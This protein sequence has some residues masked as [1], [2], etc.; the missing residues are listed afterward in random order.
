MRRQRVRLTVAF[1][2]FMVALTI[3]IT[4]R[5]LESSE[6]TGPVPIFMA[7]ERVRCPGL[8]RLSLSPHRSTRERMRASGR[9][10]RRRNLSV[11]RYIVKFYEGSLSRRVGCFAGRD[12]GGG[13][14]G[15]GEG[16]A[17][18]GDN[19]CGGGL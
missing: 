15:G 7:S 11:D 13:V 19:L 17:G 9:R 6:S 18:G 10:R 14:G 1:V 8:V 12:V 2:V 3:E 4:G 5:L 16:V